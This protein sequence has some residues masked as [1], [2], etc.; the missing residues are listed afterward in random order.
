MC[1]DIETE[2]KLFDI[3]TYVFIKLRIKAL[4]NDESMLINVFVFQ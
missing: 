1:C 3:Y 2:H 4:F